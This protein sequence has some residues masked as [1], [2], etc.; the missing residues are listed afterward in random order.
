MSAWTALLLL[1]SYYATDFWNTAQPDAWIGAL[2]AIAMLVLLREDLDA[3]PGLAALAAFLMGIGLVQKPTFLALAPLPGLAVLLVTGRSLPRR[4]VGAAWLTLVA[5]LPAALTALYFASRGE[6]AGLVEG[7]ITLNLEMSRQVVGGVVRALFYTLD[8]TLHTGALPLL[9]PAA[10][11][12]AAHLWSRDRRACLLLVAWC[13]GMALGIAA[14]RRY[15][16]YHW[17]PFVWSLGPLAG[18]GLGVLV[19]A[20]EGHARPL[21]LLAGAAVGFALFALAFPLQRRVREWAQLL[22]G[23]FPSRAA[24]MQQFPRDQSDII[25]DDLSLAQWLTTHSAPA[26]R[27][28]VWDSPLANALAGR[29]TPGRIG[30]FVPLV[31]AR[32]SR[33]EPVPLGPIQLR[34]RDEFL[35]SLEQAETRHVAVSRK[36]LAGIEPNLRKN[37]PVLFPEFHDVLAQRWHVI[38]SAGDYLIYVRRLADD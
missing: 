22:R 5:L 24:Y 35:R 31:L 32:A 33:N 26:D 19:R 13:L 10:V 15:W 25:D 17:H 1:L 12:G 4:L 8:M 14:Q 18:I 29:R 37:V 6:F 23:D 16:A 38:D 28:F 3:R 30:F 34:L 2:A 7:Y 21:R 9:L 11:V 20:G 36:A 27:V